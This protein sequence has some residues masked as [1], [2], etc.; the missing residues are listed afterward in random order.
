MGYPR[1]Y[2]HP[3]VAA[4]IDDTLAICKAHNV[5]C[6]HPHVDAGNV[7]KLLEKGFRWLMPAPT[8]SFAALEKGL[9]ASGRK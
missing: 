4:A 9:K 2:E 3:E 7:E 1:Q 8:Q 6:G 5:P